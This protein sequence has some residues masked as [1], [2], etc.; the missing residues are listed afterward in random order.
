MEGLVIVSHRLGIFPVLYA[1]KLYSVILV[2]ENM[3]SIPFRAWKHNDEILQQ[4][5]VISLNL[6]IIRWIIGGSCWI[7]AQRKL[8]EL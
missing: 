3:L 7:L 5:L 4:L 6:T 1:S 8:I 2:G